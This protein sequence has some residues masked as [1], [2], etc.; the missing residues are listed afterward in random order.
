MYVIVIWKFPSLVHACSSEASQEGISRNRT[1]GRPFHKG[2]KSLRPCGQKLANTSE[3]HECSG[4]SKQ[5]AETDGCN[6]ARAIR[7][8]EQTSMRPEARK[9]IRSLGNGRRSQIQQKLPASLGSEQTPPVEN[10]FG[11][12]ELSTSRPVVAALRFPF[13]HSA[14]TRRPPFAR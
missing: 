14:S 8:T 11:T 1:S 2:I 3:A 10:P 13:V 7:T 9:N 4:N 5:R 12:A 6:D